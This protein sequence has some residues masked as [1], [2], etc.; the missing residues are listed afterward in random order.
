VLPESR[1]GGVYVVAHRGAHNGIPENTLAAYEAAIEMG[2]DF[3]EVDLRT[4]KDG[5]IVSI[6]N[7]Q[8]DSY[9][10]DG[11]RGLVS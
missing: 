9:V 4:T 3:V 5:Y 7:K 11:R 2:V 10:T 6:H 8:I 1:H